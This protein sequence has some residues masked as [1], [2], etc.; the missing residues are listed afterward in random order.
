MDVVQFKQTW[1]VAS[2]QKEKSVAQS[3][4]RDLC[5]LL[6]VPTPTEADPTG[7]TYCFERGASK[8]GGGDGWADVWYRGNDS[9]LEKQ[10]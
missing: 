8:A 10:P 5:T 7:E 1:I 3:H 9:R 2:N 4:F 6:G